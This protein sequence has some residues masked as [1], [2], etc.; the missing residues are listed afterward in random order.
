MPNTNANASQLYQ[1]VEA[2]EDAWQSGRPPKIDDFLPADLSLRHAALVKVIHIDL[3]YR[4]NAGEKARVETYL[5]R[6]PEIADDG[7]VL[8]ELVAWEF[9]LRNRNDA[10]LTQVEYCRRFPNLA[11]QLMKRI[12]G[13]AGVPGNADRNLL[14]G[15]LAYQN[16]FIT[17]DQLLAAMQAWLFDKAKPLAD[18]LRDQ[19]ALDEQRGVLLDALVHHHVKQHGGDPQ[20]SLQAVSSASSVRRDLEQLPDPDLQAS[21]VLLRQAKGDDDPNTIVSHTAGTSTSDGTRFRIVRPHAKGGLGEVFVA[22][23]TE[24]NR[25]V[26]LKEIQEMHADNPESRSR[27]LLEA[28][29][30]GGLEHPSIVPVYGLGTYANGRPFYAMRFIRGDSLHDAIKRYHHG[31]PGAAATGERALELHKL[32]GRFIDVCQAM[33]YAHDRGVLHRD[34]K[35]GNIMLGKYGETL[36]VDWGLAKAAGKFREPG[37]ELTATEEPT[38]RPTS[39]SSAETV[40]GHAFGTPAYMSPEQAAGRLEAIGPASDVYSLGATLYA[41]LTGK[42][43]VAGNDVLAKVQRGD[44][45]RPRRIDADVPAA[46]EAICLKAMAMKPT[47]RYATP[48]LLADDIEHWLADEP[49]SVPEAIT[50]KVGRWLRRHRTLVTSTAAVLFVTTIGLVVGTALL[51]TAYSQLDERTRT[52]NAA[53]A[54]LEERTRA[55][56]TANGKLKTT[57]DNLNVARMDALDKQQQAEQAAKKARAIANFMTGLFDTAHVVDFDGK[58]RGFH[59]PA[60]MTVAKF[61]EDGQDTIPQ[62]LKDEPVVRAEM[63]DSLGS[64]YRS[65]GLYEQAEKNLVEALDIR[66]E[67][68]KPGCDE[69]A[70]TLFNLGWL[71]QEQGRFAESIKLFEESLEIT[72]KIHSADDLRTAKVMFHLGWAVGHQYD[73]PTKER[74][75]RAQKLFEQVIA[76]RKKNL[77]EDDPAVAFALIALGLTQNLEKAIINFERARSILSKKEGNEKLAQ[78]VGTYS[79]MQILRKISGNE[80]EVVKLQKEILQICRQAVG[81]AHPLSLMALGDHAGYLRSIG[82]FDEAEVAIREAMELAKLSPL[83]WHPVAYDC[84]MELADHVRHRKKNPSEAVE[85]YRR[86]MDVAQVIQHREKYDKARRYLTEALTELG[87]SHEAT[88]IKAFESRR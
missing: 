48:M 87:R 57:N 7:A 15:I 6:Y 43:P 82:K 79:K 10:S 33:Q 37:A 56:D 52:L 64:V 12:D 34:L 5:D 2:F 70:T 84:Y 60:K 4:L 32:L 67:H 66:R 86:A 80:A 75:E 3:E 27:F 8:V 9:S 24:L 85:L 28:E 39:G 1:I 71:R 31:E 78:L 20:Q 46:L 51:A 18:I 36:V 63:L 73:N 21:I 25:E 14:L 72:K 26:A 54:Q 74:T 22:L 47:G 35:P 40:A 81:D 61:L 62:L 11:A 45:P 49:V 76:I 53:Y 30:T 41:L 38:L 44:F 88:K 68:L 59:S 65:A 29:I 58:R 17:K 16:A 42:P 77:G 55:L 50:V 19:G 13:K 69:I 23:D 83:R